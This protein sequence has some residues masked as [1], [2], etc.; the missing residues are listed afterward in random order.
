[1]LALC[2]LADQV[3]QQQYPRCPPGQAENPDLIL[4]NDR[5]PDQLLI[6][7]NQ[8]SGRAA[9]SPHQFIDPRRAAVATDTL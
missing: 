4:D 1:M 5:P 3:A 8:P 7:G 6:R 2:E 9:C